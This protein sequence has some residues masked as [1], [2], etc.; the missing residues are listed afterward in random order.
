MSLKPKDILYVKILA[1]ENT[2][3][4][5]STIAIHLVEPDAGCGLL[6]IEE[7]HQ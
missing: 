6:S 5:S 4:K 7:R 2:T 3:L 1:A